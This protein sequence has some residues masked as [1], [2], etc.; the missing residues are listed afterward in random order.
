LGCGPEGKEVFVS[1][2]RLVYFSK[3]K[4]PTDGSVAVQLK[5]ILASAIKNN[6]HL[7]VTGGLV[8][9]RNY[10]MQVLEGDRSTVTKLFT[11]IS[12]DTRH[13]QIELMDVKDARERLFGAWSMGFA[14]T[15]ELIKELWAKIDV[16]GEFNPKLLTGDQIVKIIFELVKKEEGFASSRKFS[17]A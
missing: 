7:A 6:A 16:Q 12:G 8:F 9:N 10:F 13:D 14:S 17:V 3:N 11:T 2:T 4:M 5:Q 15:P 1:L